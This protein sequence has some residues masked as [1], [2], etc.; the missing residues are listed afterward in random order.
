MRAGAHAIVYF[1]ESYIH[2]GHQMKKGW[3]PAGMS[4]TLGDAD[5]GRRLMVLHAMAKDGMLETEDAVGSNFMH[6]STPTAQLV[7]EALSFDSSDYHKSIDSDAIVLSFQNRIMPSFQAKNPDKKMIIVMD[8]ASY[9]KPRDF[10]C[11][12]PSK[13]AMR[14]CLSFLHHHNVQ[15]FTAQR[16]N[17]ETNEA[18]TLTFHSPFDQDREFHY[19][20]VS[21]RRGHGRGVETER[22]KVDD[23]PRLTPRA[24]ELKK[25][26]KQHLAQHPSINKTRLEK[27]FDPLGY[28][29]IFTPPFTPEVQP[30]EL[31]WSQV[32]GEVAR[33]YKYKRSIE[34]TR[35]QTD[36][37]FD[38]ITK[39]KIENTI[40]HCH[41]YIDDF[42]KSEDAGWLRSF[43]SF[44]AFIDA[45][46]AQ[47]EV[48]EE[49]QN[50]YT[51]QDDESD[52]EE[53]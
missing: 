37:A 50:A 15:Q 34:I 4:D 31:I 1:D 13:M 25:A 7:F 40:K 38:N 46:D 21:V 12:T 5:T 18:E 16:I 20:D 29:I 24:P 47:I 42:I 36:D 3:H 43:G 9:H 27:M 44:D 19:E 26:V 10:D 23:G 2:S 22:Y 53:T 28:S 33:K 30:I 11:V 49:E 8:N 14:E 32:K 51:Q 48:P 39:E 45:Q 41:D 6:E 35:E 17:K 52:D